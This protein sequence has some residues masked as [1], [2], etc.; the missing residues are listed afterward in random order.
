MEEYKCPICGSKESVDVALFSKGTS[1]SFNKFSNNS[2][3]IRCDFDPRGLINWGTE[4]YGDGRT[5]ITF[6]PQVSTKLCTKC[7]FVSFHA[8]ELA[9]A[10][11]KDLVIIQEKDADLLDEK[12]RLL[13]EKTTLSVQLDEIPAQEGK[14]EELI[15]SEDITIRQ[16]KE[17]QSELAGLRDRKRTIG[18]RIRGINSR[19]E[20]IDYNRGL[21]L[22]AKKHVN[23]NTIDKILSYMK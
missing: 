13:K 21:L 18:G 23:G 9:K 11:A 19:I 17:Y 10:I 12:E 14:L 5:D 15:K 22:D 16:Q 6:S 3:Q 8:L 2:S 20:E 1:I 7:G 4:S